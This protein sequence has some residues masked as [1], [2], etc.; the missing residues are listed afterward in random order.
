MKFDVIV[1]NPPYQLADGGQA[2]S[3]VPIYHE[4]VSQAKKIAHRYLIMIIPARWYVGG[5]GLE[6]F[7]DQMLNDQHIRILHDF[8]D[9]S[10]CFPGVEIKGGVCFFLWDRENIGKCDIYTHL[11]DGIVQD[12]RFLL[13]EGMDTFIRTPKEMSV[14][15]KIVS[16][17]E[18][19]LSLRMNSGRYFGFHTQLV[20]DGDNGKL[21]TADGK[22][23]FPVQRKNN[24][25]YD[26]RVYV[27]HGD[28]WISSVNVK[29]KSDVDKWKVLIPNVGNPGSTILGRVKLSA[30]GTCHSN[31]YNH[32][33][34]TSK[35]EAENVRSY[36][37]C[38]FTR[39][40][41]GMKTTT[42]HT[43]PK[44]FGLVPMQ[45][46]SKPWVDEELYKKYNLTADEIAFIESM[47]KPME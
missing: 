30:P 38:K 46:F 6:K 17:H 15:K 43:P 20:W 21:Q 12:N 27:A 19:S 9:A 37:Q 23:S 5:R 14:Y 40:L 33:L 47:I 2:A 44:S 13:E 32:Y 7:R 8:P 18:P 36:L 16:L 26:V 34:A 29:N 22:S 25:A 3:A 42:Q 4:F 35:E 31:T 11:Q 1:G 39:F 24:A 45:D 10:D 41:V 28:C